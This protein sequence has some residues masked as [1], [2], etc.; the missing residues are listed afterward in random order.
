MP[1]ENQ[2]DNSADA[3]YLI[4]YPRSFVTITGNVAS[5]IL[6][7]Q[8]LRLS[9]SAIETDG[10]ISKSMS[11]WQDLT[12]MGRR[13]QDLARKSLKEINFLEEELR[14]TPATL[15]FRLKHD[16]LAKLLPEANQYAENENLDSNLVC[17]PEWGVVDEAASPANQFAACI[18]PFEV[19]VREAVSHPQAGMQQINLRIFAGRVNDILYRLESKLGWLKKGI[20]LQSEQG[21]EKNKSLDQMKLMQFG[22]LIMVFLI[23]MLCIAIWN[24]QPDYQSNATSAKQVQKQMNNAQQNQR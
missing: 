12:G 18:K 24:G 10:W 20:D 4:S 1:I 19:N 21:A 3:D 22:L 7:S 5:A 14:G 15:Y 6:L 2:A 11:E 8:L 13:E 23:L 9:K 17:S 16:E